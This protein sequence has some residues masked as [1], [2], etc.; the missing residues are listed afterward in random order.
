MDGQETEDSTYAV[1]TLDTCHS[2]IPANPS[3]PRMRESKPRLA[4]GIC[5]NC[6]FV[7]LWDYS[8]FLFSR[9]SSDRGKAGTRQLFTFAGARGFGF[10]PSRE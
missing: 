8:E 2:V 5:L 9:H 10:P 7:G 3:F 4:G 1:G 6:A